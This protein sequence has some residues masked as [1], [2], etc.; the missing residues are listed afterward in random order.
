[1]VPVQFFRTVFYL[2]FLFELPAAWIRTVSP[3][4][5]PPRVFNMFH[6]VRKTSGTTA[7]SSKDNLSDIG[8]MFSA[9]AFAYSA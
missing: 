9:E 2:T 8:I 4:A 1:M 3:V 6:A 5:N 7:H